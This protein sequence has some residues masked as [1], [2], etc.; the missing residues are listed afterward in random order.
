MALCSVWVSERACV[1]LQRCVHVRW[2][3]GDSDRWMSG[4]PLK[5]QPSEVNLRDGVPLLLLQTCCTE[6]CKVV[7]RGNR[8]YALN[9]R[10]GERGSGRQCARRGHSIKTEAFPWRRHA[11]PLTKATT[12]L[13][14]VP[15]INIIYWLTPFGLFQPRGVQLPLACWWE[16]MI[17]KDKDTFSHIFSNSFETFCKNSPHDYLS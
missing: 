2:L 5:L 4:A 3:C 16:V 12:R 1:R 7:C 9:S 13:Q 10:E 8:S 6:L 15:L 11:P 14:R 17:S